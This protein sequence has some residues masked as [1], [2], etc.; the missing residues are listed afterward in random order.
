M[1][2]IESKLPLVGVKPEKSKKRGSII[3]GIALILLINSFVIIWVGFLKSDDTEAELES[4]ELNSIVRN[5]VK[6][7]LSFMDTLKNF[8][9]SNLINLIEI[10]DSNAMTQ[11]LELNKL[12]IDF[13]LK[14][15]LVEVN[16]SCKIPSITMPTP[17]NC[18]TA[19]NR[20]FNGLKKDPSK[21]GILIQLGFDA[22]TLEIYMHQVYDIVDYFFIIESTTSH[23]QHQKKPLIWQLLQNQNRFAIF[24]DKI[25]NFVLDDSDTAKNIND[26]SI[27]ALESQQEHSRWTKFLEWNKNYQYFSDDDIL[28]FGDADEIPSRQNLLL[29]KHCSI[30]RDVTKAIDIGIWFPLSY[31]KWA[32]KTDFPVHRSVPYSLGDPSFWTVSNAKKFN[33]NGNAPTRM[34]GKSGHFLLGGAHLS[35]YL[36]PPFAMIKMLTCSECNGVTHLKEWKKLIDD[37][38]VRGLEKFF[39]D[40]NV[41]LYSGRTVSLEDL[42]AKNKETVSLPWLGALFFF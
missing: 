26:N 19:G 31:I 37:K 3:A 32:F 11:R 16:N 18:L 25:V 28:G 42:D 39:I 24:K 21:V 17:L 20:I 14:E 7:S 5:D 40:H 27:W 4:S 6:N 9:F 13:I 15:P 33:V 1:C 22:D 38:N 23:L 30:S 29:L 8:N 36:Y 2:D 10:E 12:L 41:N 34:R 35:N